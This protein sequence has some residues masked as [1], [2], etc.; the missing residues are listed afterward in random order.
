VGSKVYP[1]EDLVIR[2]YETRRTDAFDLQSEVLTRMFKLVLAGE[3]DELISYARKTVTDVKNGKIPIDKLVISKTVKSESQYK[4]PDKMAN[5]LA[6]RKLKDLGYEFV[7]GMKVSYLVTNGH[8]V[9]Q[10]VEPYIDGRDISILPDWDYYAERMALTMARI[11]EGLDTETDWD[12][13]AL[14]TGVQQKS[15]FSESFSKPLSKADNIGQG[16]EPSEIQ[17]TGREAEKQIS[18]NDQVKENTQSK[19][20][21][22]KKGGINLDDFL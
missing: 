13:K 4:D 1:N 5:V 6:M 7:P 22:K 20:K 16:V 11:T 3:N 21:G 8:K 15:I 14:L 12:S 19:V 9:P 17:T 18:S 2:G 10:D